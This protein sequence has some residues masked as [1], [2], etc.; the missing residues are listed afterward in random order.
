MCIGDRLTDWQ[1]WSWFLPNW[2]M[3]GANGKQYLV[4]MMVII[5]SEIEID[6]TVSVIMYRFM[7]QV[8]YPLIIKKISKVW[9]KYI[10]LGQLSLVVDIKCQVIR[11]HYGSYSTKHIRMSF[12][13]TSVSPSL[14]HWISCSLALSHQYV[15]ENCY[16][17]LKCMN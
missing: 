13:R 9:Y 2:I 7:C 14:M 5:A 10:L 17:I 1:R 6:R 8:I 12:W 15:S 11:G 3:F 16:F 4:V